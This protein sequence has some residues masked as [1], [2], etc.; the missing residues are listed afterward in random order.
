MQEQVRFA[1]LDLGIESPVYTVGHFEDS[2]DFRD[3]WVDDGPNGIAISNTV[4]STLHSNANVYYLQGPIHQEL[5]S[6][7]A[8][9]RR[10]ARWRT[11]TE[12]DQVIDL[13][14]QI[15]RK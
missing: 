14:S 12:A 4:K 2:Q 1:S 11:T 7:A 3:Y 9:Q 15:V 5:K 8:A 13:N 6:R 10:D